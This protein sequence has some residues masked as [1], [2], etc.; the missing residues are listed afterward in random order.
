MNIQLTQNQVALVD[1]EDFERINQYKWYAA[2]D[3]CT[4][5][6]YVVRSTGN[7]KMARFIMNCPSGMLVDHKD[8][9]TLN[10]QKA[11][12]RVCTFSE[13]MRN[14]RK[15]GNFS[16]KYKGVSWN[17]RCKKWTAQIIL[18]GIFDQHYKQHLG[19]FY[20]EE[21]AAL[22]YDIAAVKHF[23]EFAC[24]NFSTGCQI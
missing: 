15:L 12:L 7:L 19:Y 22:A 2:W 6:F 4:Q 24:L 16:S 10:N 9:N 14:S 8:H 5:G 23:E 21:K 1:D 13:N 20:E 3:D 17:K 18:T 11:N